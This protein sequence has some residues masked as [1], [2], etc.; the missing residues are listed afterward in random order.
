MK[1]GEHRM[2]MSHSTMADAEILSR[3][4]IKSNNPE[5][6]PEIDVALYENPYGRCVP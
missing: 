3:Q 4:H 1:Q 2:Y 6:H 5:E